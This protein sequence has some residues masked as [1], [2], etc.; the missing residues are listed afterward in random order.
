MFSVRYLQNLVQKGAAD[1]ALVR[2]VSAFPAVAVGLA[3]AISTDVFV[4][5]NQPV[6]AE[7]DVFWYLLDAATNFAKP[8]SETTGNVVDGV[9][10]TA[11]AAAQADD[12]NG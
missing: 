5:H 6:N 1:Y 9:E 8:L 4:L 7:Y 12:C 2:I 3:A 10:G 11:S